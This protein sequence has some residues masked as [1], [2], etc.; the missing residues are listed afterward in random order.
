MTNHNFTIGGDMPVN[1]MGFGA[2]RITGSGIW[3]PPA[4]K[5]SALKVLKTCVNL[6]VNFIDTADAYG[7]EVSEN[8]IAEA[9]YPYPEGLVIA[10]KGG[11]T[12]QGPNRWTPKADP[13]YIE[14]AL[15]GSLKRLKLECIDLYQL[16]RFDPNVPMAET[17][18]KLRELQQ[19]GF[20]RHLGLS[21]VNEKELNESVK[22]I[23][24][25]SVQNR[26]SL[27]YRKWESV[28]KWC[29]TNQAA[30]IPWYPLD[31]GDLENKTLQQIAQK[32]QTTVYQIAIAWLLAHSPVMLPIPGTSSVS[33]LQENMAAADI[34]LDEDDMRSLGEIG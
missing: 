13:E 18:G 10:T 14:K 26:Y 4:D 19:A 25:V 30:F 17:L 16:H 5:E 24:V 3:G 11:L 20:I 6:G 22:Y 34:I 15:K 29:E 9:L 31:A 12:R 32:H 28:L 27:R 1:R 33:H 7:P 2:M 23:D 21:E 8:L